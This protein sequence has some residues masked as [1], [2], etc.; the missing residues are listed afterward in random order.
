[1]L[2]R[3]TIQ[4]TGS[5]E[6][7]ILLDI[8]YLDNANQKPV[9]IFCH[10]FKGFKDWGLFNATAE[11]F[12]KSGFLFVKFNFSYNGTTAENPTEFVDLNAFGNN[13]YSIELNDLEN[14]IHWVLNSEYI[15]KQI[16]NEKIYLI[17]HSRGGGISIIKSAENKII[18]KLITWASVSY[19]DRSIPESHLEQ[20]KKEGVYYI[21]N[22]R[23]NQQM[24]LFYQFYENFSANKQR[25]DILARAKEVNIPTLVVHG[26]ADET[27]PVSEA[28]QLTDS[29]S[30]A[31]CLVIEKASH[32]FDVTHPFTSKE[33]PTNFQRVIDES[34]RFLL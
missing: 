16:D 8:T 31:Q 1:M 33:I 15:A 27:V 24:P 18:K 2:I 28:N 29:I 30:E 11:Q 3:N 13:N 14:V 6:K 12:A 17:G 21:F 9:V 19:F 32:T 7:P 4:I 5:L 25:L 10:G 26:T 34:I 22:S 23:T 20:W